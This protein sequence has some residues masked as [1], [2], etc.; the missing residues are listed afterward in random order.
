MYFVLVDFCTHI[1]IYHYCTFDS[2]YIFYHH[3]YTYIC[4]ILHNIC[5]ANTFDSVIIL[6]TLKF[7][8]S[9]LSRT[10]T[11]LDRSL[12]VLQLA[13]HLSKLNANG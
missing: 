12:R 9:V 2:S 6:P 5:F 10:H 13:V 3:I 4:M 7:N 1:N 8:S 11:L